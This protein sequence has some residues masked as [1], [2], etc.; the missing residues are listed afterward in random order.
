MNWK[1]DNELDIMITMRVGTCIIQAISS[2]MIVP[3]VLDDMTPT[4]INTGIEH[5]S[6]YL[7]G[8]FHHDLTSRPHHRWSLVRNI[9]NPWSLYDLFSSSVAWCAWSI[10]LHG[11]LWIL[12]LFQGS[13]DFFWMATKDFLWMVWQHPNHQLIGG[14]HPIVYS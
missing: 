14:K 8:R 12:G 2:H 13:G 7:L 6:I 11:S 9:D 10:W 1:R 3:S 5:N 4:I